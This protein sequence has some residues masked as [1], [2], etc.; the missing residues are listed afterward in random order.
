MYLFELNVFKYF[1]KKYE[2]FRSGGIQSTNS[3][4]KLSELQI[5]RPKT[6]KIVV[7]SVKQKKWSDFLLAEI[8]YKTYI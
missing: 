6:Y 4:P 1:L 5:I 3:P 8:P 7:L 2:R